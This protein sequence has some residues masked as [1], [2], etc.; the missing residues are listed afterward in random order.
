MIGGKLIN[1]D[2][3]NIR[4]ILT[5]D[6]RYQI[7][8]FQRDFSWNDEN[9]NEFM[10]DLLQ[11][12]DDCPN[13]EY[14]FGIVFLHKTD[15]N[16]KFVVIDGQQ[17]LTTALIFLTVAR[18]L[19]KKLENT[20]VVNELNKHIFYDFYK[21]PRLKLNNRNNEYFI[22]HIVNRS[23]N[24]SAGPQ[25]VALTNKK[26][27]NSYKKIYGI[28]EKMIDESNNGDQN[29]H[30]LVQHFLKSFII[31]VNT[32][33]PKDKHR[34][35]DSVNNK[36][37]K[38]SENDFVKNSLF[39]IIERNG[40]DLEYC[41]DQWT[42]MLTNIENAHVDINKFLRDYLIAY[43]KRV[44]KKHVSQT[45]IEIVKKDV[46]TSTEL[47]DKLCEISLN[48]YYMINPPS[49]FTIHQKLC[50]NLHT[51]RILE[52]KS[53][54]PVLLFGYDKL[55]SIEKFEQLTEIMTKF[56]FRSRTICNT[57]ANAMERIMVEV[58]NILKTN[59][60]HSLGNDDVIKLIT[61]YLIDSPAYHK[62]DFKNYFESFNTN[63]NLVASYVLLE[64]NNKMSGNKIESS[65]CFID[66]IMPKSLDHE[67]KS[68]LKIKLDIENDLELIS[69][70]KNSLSKIA[71]MTPISKST[72]INSNSSY[73]AKRDNIYKKSDYII[74]KKLNADDW[75]ISEIDDR[76][77]SFADHADMIWSL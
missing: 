24:E 9:I 71:N 51:L 66:H 22:N 20:N 44:Q 36:G 43:H 77:K 6:L 65:D 47:I 54:Y 8:L 55:N 32:I 21:N 74:T 72:L 38:L 31:T 3:E 33:Q 75:T 34:I 28:L 42:K 57:E 39:E 18:D 48:Y 27:D 62:N 52:S 2:E 59:D 15:T 17:R 26:L 53:V 68:Y 16:D 50:N 19:F 45:I 25:H 49:H 58:C 13:E 37:L 70:Y 4:D 7:P 23:M 40:G 46:M 63:N 61:S 35:F 14:Y 67:W 41:H 56:F 64:I 69:T 12:Y 29:V 73:S 1:S 60:Q 11:H 76:Q 5:H 30:K 10:N